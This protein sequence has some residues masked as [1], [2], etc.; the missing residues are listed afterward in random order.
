MKTVII[1]HPD[2]SVENHCEIII[3]TQ[4]V[5]AVLYIATV[6]AMKDL[7][8]DFLASVGACVEWLFN[9]NMGLIDSRFVRDHLY[10][11]ERV[12]HTLSRMLVPCLSVQGDRIRGFVS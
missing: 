11:F 2:G 4:R 10:L 12:E 9:M 8:L 1:R 6:I 5:H 3:D 7:K